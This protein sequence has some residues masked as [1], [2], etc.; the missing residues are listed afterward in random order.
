[1]I[2]HTQWLVFDPDGRVLGFVEA[3]RG[4]V[5]YQ[6]GADYVLGSRV[7]DLEVEYVEV[8]PLRRRPR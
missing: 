4:L 2:P 6:I 5:I 3:P 7:G 1:M 8:W